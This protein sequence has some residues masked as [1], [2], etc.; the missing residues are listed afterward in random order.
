MTPA[1]QCN[2]VAI[3]TPSADISGQFSLFRTCP[4]CHIWLLYMEAHPLNLSSAQFYKN[5]ALILFH[6]PDPQRIHSQTKG[7]SEKNEVLYRKRK[8]KIATREITLSSIDKQDW[9]LQ[10][11]LYVYWQKA[12]CNSRLGLFQWKMKQG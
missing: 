4:F 1:M 7:H 10:I 9:W 2:K 11:S 3:I 5:T 12:V 6:P 8:R